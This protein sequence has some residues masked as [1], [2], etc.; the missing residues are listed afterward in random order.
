VIII[1]EFNKARAVREVIEGGVSHMWTVSMLQLHQHA[2]IALDEPA[3]M[4][5][6]VESVKYFKDIEEIAGDKMPKRVEE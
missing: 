3:T 4:E 2:V 5:L 6:Q 1:T